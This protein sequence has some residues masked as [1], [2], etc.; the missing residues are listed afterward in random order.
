MMKSFALLM[1]AVCASFLGSTSASYAW[2][3]LG[4]QVVCEIAY[5]E[6]TPTTRSVVDG[7]MASDDD[8]HSFAQ[9]CVFPDHPRIR[10][11]E[12]FVNLQR[13]ASAIGVD[14][15]PTTDTCVV[16]AIETDARGLATMTDKGRQLIL[17]KSIG[18]WV[19]DIHQ[20]L[21]VSYED[22]RG[23]NNINVTTP[24]EGSLHGVWDSCIIEEK[25]GN[26]YRS[27]ATGLSAEIQASDRAR[28]IATSLDEK[29]IVGWAN[30][31]YAIATEPSVGYCVKEGTTCQY[32]STRVNF[33]TPK[34][35]VATDDAYLAKQA[36]VVRQRLKMAGVRLGDLLNRLFDPQ[37]N[38][39]SLQATQFDLADILKHSK[40]VVLPS[41]HSLSAG[42]PENLS[43]VATSPTSATSEALIQL[44]IQQLNARIERLELEIQ[45][46]K[47]KR[48]GQDGN[49]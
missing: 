40:P 29:T 4:H 18:H 46:L 44:E 20:P 30:E 6:L 33:S 36:P 11:G 27:I 34:K 22:D 9:A 19:G 3:D 15:C 32:D 45:T 43:E 39:A 38:V 35:T 47:N 7:L 31:S 23:G 25:I 1:A 48:G 41:L 10:A 28:W 17:L 49:G 42:L 2:G 21:H 8:F 24:C 12:H 5:R 14:S 26:D 13:T 37:Y 16:T